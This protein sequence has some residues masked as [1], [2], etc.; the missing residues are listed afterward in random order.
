MRVFVTGASG[1]I[2][3][4][5]VDE[6]LANGHQVIGLARSDA[7]AASIEA[8]G[9]EVLRGDLDDL[10][11]LRSGATAADAVVHLA[12]KHDFA[13]PEVSNAA[14]R[15]S[16]QV[17]GD[18]LA[19][20]GKPLVVASGTAIPHPDGPITED[21]P[22]PAHGPESMRGGS[23]NLALEFA[24]KGVR[25]IVARFAPTVHGKD[26]HGFVSFITGS[27]RQGG[28]ALYAGDG[29]GQWSA[30]HVTDAARAVRLALET[31]PAGTILHVAG[32][33]GVRTGDIAAAIGAG[34]GLPVES[35][36][37]EELTERWGFIGMVFGMDIP[38]SSEAT[39]KLL[40][41]EPT[42]PTLLKDIASGAYFPVDAGA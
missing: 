28:A 22:N 3:S 7:S 34:L 12:N 9:A 17:L 8:K 24:D 41:W 10:D 16:T 36:S 18:T 19:G 39:R 6:L 15:A 33:Q 13:H 38:A 26:D 40:G 35:V 20:T 11:S 21:V 23:E 32:E 31:A 14:E 1:W 37:A 2:G 42:G 29:S 25:S 30:V 5:V 4:H 27:A